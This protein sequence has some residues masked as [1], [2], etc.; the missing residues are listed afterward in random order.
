MGVKA[1]C[2]PR[3]CNGDAVNTSIFYKND[4]PK[5][6]V[7]S[8]V[9]TL[10]LGGGHAEILDD[11]V[12]SDSYFSQKKDALGLVGFSP[13]QKSTLVLLM[14]AYGTSADQLEDLTRVSESTTLKNLQCFCNTIISRYGKEY[15][16]ALTKEYLEMILH[17]H[18]GKSWPG[19]ICS[20][21][22]MHWEW[23]N[24]QSIQRSI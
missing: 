15:L 2:T 11:L 24:S 3:F 7:D 13:R 18:E 4:L 20:L 21:D 6:K 12:T 14:L 1:T 16:R 8:L 5:K 23:K 10:P 9:W 17:L 22:I 19:L